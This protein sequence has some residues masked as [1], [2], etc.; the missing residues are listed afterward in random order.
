M[1]HKINLSITEASGVLHEAVGKIPKRQRAEF[2]RL[3]A[4]LSIVSAANE[5]GG[6][7]Q[8]IEGDVAITPQTPSLKDYE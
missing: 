7:E 8:R 6:A 3:H 2:I 4:T 1:T 5:L